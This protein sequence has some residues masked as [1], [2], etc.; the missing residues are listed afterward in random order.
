MNDFKE[1][2][3]IWNSIQWCIQNKS[4]NTWYDSVWFHV[5]FRRSVLLNSYSFSLDEIVLCIISVPAS[6]ITSFVCFRH[7]EDTWPADYYAQ[8]KIQI[9]LNSK[10]SVARPSLPSLIYLYTVWCHVQCLITQARQNKM[11]SSQCYSWSS[12]PQLLRFLNAI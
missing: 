1:N 9:C 3:S 7:M 8:M 11:V 5:P 4:R 12:V 6:L 2:W 10:S